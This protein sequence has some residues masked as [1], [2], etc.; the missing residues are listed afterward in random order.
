MNTSRQTNW[1]QRLIDVSSI[2]QSVFCPVRCLPSDVSVCLRLFPSVCSACVLRVSLV[3]RHRRPSPAPRPQSPSPVHW[4]PNA[5][6]V[7]CPQ[8]NR[9]QGTNLCR[10]ANGWTGLHSLHLSSPVPTGAPNTSQFCFS[11]GPGVHT[12]LCSPPCAFNA[13]PPLTPPFRSFLGD[14]S[15]STAQFPAERDKEEQL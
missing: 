1:T 2:I 7:P 12:V 15:T 5:S 6:S 10:L 11:S 8:R 3:S 9:C 4:R 13:A 14:A